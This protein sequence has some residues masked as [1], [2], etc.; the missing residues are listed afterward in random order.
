M[1]GV[2]TCA[3]PIFVWHFERDGKV[4]DVV[5]ALYTHR[6]A[7][8]RD[9]HVLGPGLGFWWRTEKPIEAGTRKG[10]HWRALFGIIGG[11]NDGVTRYFSLF[12]GKIPLK[13]KPVWEPRRRRKAIKAETELK[14]AR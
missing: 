11:G 8:G 3:L 10:L 2:Q 6:K 9:L 12:G 14:V 4:T 1:T 5:P 13:P 7:K